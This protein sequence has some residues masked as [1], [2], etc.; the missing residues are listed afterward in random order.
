MF[1]SK[2]TCERLGDDGRLPSSMVSVGHA[3]RTVAKCR[4]AD[5]VGM[6]ILPLHINFVKVT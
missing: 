3:A 6:D 5:G 1:I 4:D 2:G